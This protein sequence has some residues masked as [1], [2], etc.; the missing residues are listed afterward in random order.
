MSNRVKTK[1]KL[2]HYIIVILLAILLSIGLGFMVPS[3]LT[4]ERSLIVNGQAV[5]KQNRYNEENK[6]ALHNQ[7][8]FLG[9]SIFEFYD[10]TKFFPDHTIY[11]RGISGDRTIDIINRINDNALSINPSIIVLHVGT[12]D[13]GR[14]LSIEIITNN[15]ETIIKMIREHDENIAIIIDSVYPVNNKDKIMYNLM[16]GA[17]DSEDIIK[18]NNEFSRIANLYECSFIDSYHLFI[19]D[20]GDLKSSFTIDGLHLTD[21]AYKIVTQT[22]LPFLG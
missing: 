9:D 14:K 18:L 2:L 20:K 11:N 13:L 7:I 4:H 12:N 15:L 22:I 8:V 17:R 5:I 1:I 6:T 10:T 19:D 3:F 21:A 16:V